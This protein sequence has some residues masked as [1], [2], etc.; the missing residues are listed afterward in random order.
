[1]SISNQVKFKRGGT[2]SA[3]ITITPTGSLTNLVG[4]AIQSSVLDSRSL[5][6]A[7]QVSIPDQNGLVFSLRGDNTKSWNLGPAIWDIK[8]IRDGVVFYSDTIELNI[9]KPATPA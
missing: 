4:V 1:M 6:Y 7:L 5:P 2:F 9:V 8:F 3:E